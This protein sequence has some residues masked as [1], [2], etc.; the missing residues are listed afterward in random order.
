M[1][2]TAPVYGAEGGLR[3]RPVRIA[4]AFAAGPR[5]RS[6]SAREPRREPRKMPN[7][8]PPPATLWGTDSAG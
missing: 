2:T 6:D 3:L 1:N 5:E 7:G 8:D 4:A